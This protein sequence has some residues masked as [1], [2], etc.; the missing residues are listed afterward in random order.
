M[1]VNH[2]CDIC[3]IKCFSTGV[4]FLFSFQSEWEFRWVSERERERARASICCGVFGS[5][6]RLMHIND[7]QCETNEY[8]KYA[9]G[10]ITAASEGKRSFMHYSLEKHIYVNPKWDNMAKANGN[11]PCDNICVKMRKRRSIRGEMSASLRTKWIGKVSVWSWVRRWEFMPRVK[12]RS[13][14]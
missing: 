9:D 14:N 10:N 13:E 1:H 5:R 11:L 8:L 4:C 3:W 2:L 12:S 7:K 6:Y